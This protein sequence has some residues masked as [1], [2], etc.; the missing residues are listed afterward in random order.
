MANIFRFVKNIY[1]LSIKILLVFFA[2]ILAIG[3][4]LY[5]FNK[6]RPKT[7]VDLAK[8][9]RQYIYSVINNPDLNS[10]KQGKTAIGLYRTIFC[11]VIGEACTNN[12]EDANQ[13][14]NHSLLGSITNL[15]V[16]PYTNPPASGIYWAQATLQKAGFIPK[17]YAATGIGFA[18][19][20]PYL[21]IWTIFRD[22]AYAFLVILLIA[23]GFMIMFRMKINPQTVIGIE[24]ALPKIVMALIL[25]T[26]SFAIAGL[27]IDLMYLVILVIISVLSSLNIGELNPAN[28]KKLQ[29]D[30]IGA[31]FTRIWPY[32]GDNAYAVGN[33][34]IN[35][36]PGVAQVVLKGLVSALITTFIISRFH[37]FPEKAA[38][39]LSGIGFSGEGGLLGISAGGGINIGNTPLLVNLALML[40][41]FLIL[42]PIAANILLA[43]I[44]VFTLGFLLFRV[45]FLLLTSYIKVILLIIFAPLILMFEA[46][47]GKNP[48]SYWI[49]N[50]I[51]EL[52]AFPAVIIISIAGYAIT[53]SMTPSSPAWQP[54]FLYGIEPKTFSVLIGTGIILLTPE[55]IKI[56]RELLGAKGVPLELGLGTFLGGAGVVAGGGMGMVGS[57]SSLMLAFPTLRKRAGG[58]PLIGNLVQDD[59]MRFDADEAKKLQEQ[60]TLWKAQDDMAAAGMRGESGH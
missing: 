1:S 40:I 12:P 6:D 36:L 24:N 19:I 33:A 57:F 11:T 23:I 27:L 2:F 54:P 28:L 49:R 21:K 31:G 17:T 22:V 46:V 59:K 51:G 7:N 47:P 18:L 60:K 43:L 48:F 44:F 35:I 32:G 29:N 52:I 20:S 30:Y 37:Y 13:N 58:L 55:L 39:A 10:T 3:S 56:L 25:I 9:N 53:H 26:F 16:Y 14:F 38:G 5:F 34:L 15:I 42:N 4:L 8:E 45:F 50:M 41:S